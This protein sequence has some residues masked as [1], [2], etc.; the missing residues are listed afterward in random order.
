MARDVD[1]HC[2][3]PFCP[4]GDRGIFAGI[5]KNEEAAVDG[6]AWCRG[7]HIPCRTDTGFRGR[8]VSPVLDS[9][10]HPCIAVLATVQKDA[11]WFDRDSPCYGFRSLFYYIHTFQSDLWRVES[12]I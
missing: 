11:A 8:G 3:Q 4:F 6:D 10:L 9:V 5:F 2:V 1:Q 12:L 7:C